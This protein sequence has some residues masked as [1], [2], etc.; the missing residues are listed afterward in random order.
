[1]NTNRQIIFRSFRVLTYI[2]LIKAVID[3]AML[4]SRMASL[5]T[6][7]T[8]ATA[9]GFINIVA[10]VLCLMGIIELSVHYTYAFRIMVAVITITF[11]TLL[12]VVLD[13]RHMTNSN[14][15]GAS[16]I[17]IFA[18]ILVMVIRVLIGAALLFYMR[19]NGEIIGKKAG[20][21]GIFSSEKIGSIYLYLNSI[22]ALFS[23]FAL[24]SNSKLSIAAA[25]VFDIVGIVLEL[26]IYYRA[27]DAAIMFWK[28][29]TAVIADE[30]VNV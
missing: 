29:H 20:D 30:L 13:V 10:C 12:L 14:M 26:L 11:I 3:L 27:A 17:R 25:V 2:V 18:L 16:S 6:V 7:Y 5:T 15:M 4:I 22:G 9:A 24:Y 8:I 28:S 19:G 21:H 1:M 23:T